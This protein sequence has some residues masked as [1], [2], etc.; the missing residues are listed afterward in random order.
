MTNKYLRYSLISILFLIPFVG[1]IV[2][3]SFFFPYITPK[4]IAFRLLVEL[5]A[6]FYILLA[7]REPAYRPRLTP[8]LVAF[9]SFLGVILIADIFGEYPFKAFFSNF[10]R[11]E[12]FVTHA[13][14]FVYFLM[15]TSVFTTETLWKRFFQ[16]SLGVSVIMGLFG[17]NQLFQGI[18][19]ID[20]QLG[21]S[22]YLGAYMLFHILIGT[23]LLI[24]HMQKVEKDPFIKWSIGLIYAG[25]ILF[26]LYIFYYTG[27][28]GALLGLI[29]GSLFA[30][31]V[32]AIFEKNKTLKIAGISVL[33]LIIIV[34]GLLAG[35]K[36]SEFVKSHNLLAR[37]SQLATFDP[38]GLEEFA[39]TQGR[40]RFAIWGIALKG[41]EER[42]LLGW[43]QDNFNYV[44]NKYYDPKI[45]DQESWFDRAHNV[46]FDWLIA[47]GVF[48]L[49]TY[50]SLFMLCLVSIWKSRVHEKEKHF[51]F[52]DKVVL[53]SLLIAYFIHNIFVF[54]S[55]TSYILFF[56][57]LA[58]VNIHEKKDFFGPSFYKHIKETDYITVGSFV[59]LIVG[60]VSLYYF[61]MIPFVSSVSLIDALKY[62]SNAMNQS[63]PM[64]FNAVVDSYKK[65][66]SPKGP[67]TAEAREQLLQSA[68]NIANSS[69]LSN[70]QKIAFITLA[71][72][73]MKKQID[74][75]PSDA[76]YYLFY[77][78]FLAQFQPGN[79]SITLDQVISYLSKAHELSPQKQTM[80]FQIG[81][82][83]V[84]NKE[85]KKAVEIFK[86]AYDLE[87]NYA[88]A[89]VFYAIALIYTNNNTLA[90]QILVPLQG[91]AY[92]TDTNLIKAYYDTKQN[93][94]I[95]SILQLKLKIAGE[96]VAAGRKEDAIN[97]IKEVISINPSF[98]TQGEAYIK[99]IQDS[100]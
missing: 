12:G 36:Q 61:V 7:L 31:V 4:N 79:P 76:R 38:K 27:T 17:L 45:Y 83:Y 97:E 72:D 2:S 47:G 81:S 19:R 30:S 55:I 100:K 8:I 98:K 20:A 85:Y 13:H 87:N 40:G 42:P 9:L 18:G 77:G 74:E 73:E 65:A 84:N 69:A 29:A 15:L 96:Y 44:F 71:N 62:Q 35:F 59:G 88:Q 64:V 37:F 33:A 58:F 41:F 11:M 54:D 25:V 51:I 52:S 70:E 3:S 63:N 6:I 68:P 80:L 48:G 93:D 22:T 34:V 99:Q 24:R 1:L 5:G 53:T 28:R 91:T 50:L 90:D 23:F 75:T 67:G 57:V 60:G 78:S 56:A 82:V 46:F 10:E 32:F 16:T 86:Q 21:N 94:K 95:V 92:V 89:R 14:L 66:I 43:G 49:L 39:T 26:D